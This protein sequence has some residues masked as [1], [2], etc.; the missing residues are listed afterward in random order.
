V[1]AGTYLI[2]PAVLAPWTADHEISIEREIFPAVIEAGHPVFGFVAETYWM[3]LGTPEKY[4]QAHYDLLAGAVQGVTYDAPWIAPTADVEQGA[5]LG[6]RSTIGAEARVAAGATVE[7]SVL[8]PGAAVGAGAVVRASIIGPG[9]K[10]GAEANVSGCVLGAG[11]T[12]PDGLT[13]ADAK[14]PTDGIATAS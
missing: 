13:I 1:N 3:D 11:S 4:L 7:D 12:V 8:H 10:V 9:A 6:A 2:D 5:T 14:V